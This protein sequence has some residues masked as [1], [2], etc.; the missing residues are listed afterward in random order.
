MQAPAEEWKAEATVAAERALS[1][2]GTS[3]AHSMHSVPMP[4]AAPLA[5]P[6]PALAAVPEAAAEPRGR[7]DRV[8]G[9]EAGVPAW[10]QAAAATGAEAP[11]SANPSLWDRLNPRQLASEA[12]AGAR[13][14]MS[15]C[16]C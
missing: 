13:C 10:P 12:H 5:A 14:C 11:L 3:R 8:V 6:P 7:D 9:G 4:D 15:L 16:C 2:V 1:A